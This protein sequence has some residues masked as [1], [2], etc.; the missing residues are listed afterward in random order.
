MNTRYGKGRTIKAIKQH[1][2]VAKA[3]DLWR[4]LDSVIGTL[5]MNRHI[6]FDC[7]R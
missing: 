4:E 6:G 2:D 5:L 7:R 1:D 3:S